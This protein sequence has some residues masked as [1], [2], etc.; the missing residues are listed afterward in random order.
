MCSVSA[1]TSALNFS[2][3]GPVQAMYTA[4]S[5]S[6][7][8][9]GFGEVTYYKRRP[10]SIFP[11]GTLNGM[12]AVWDACF[13]CV[14][15]RRV[16]CIFFAREM[17]RKRDRRTSVTTT[18]GSPIYALRMSV[19]VSSRSRSSVHQGPIDRC[20]IR[21]LLCDTMKFGGERQQ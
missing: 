20:P 9:S 11:H 17:N 13:Y 8:K 5:L 2:W 14:R 15:L 4:R 12:M 18:R 21:C 10:I 3:W 19:Y 7:P 1:Y 6:I 16:C